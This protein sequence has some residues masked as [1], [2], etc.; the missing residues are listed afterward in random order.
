MNITASRNSTTKV[1]T[2]VVAVTEY[3]LMVT[4]VHILPFLSGADGN[5]DESGRMH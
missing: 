4:P 5:V 3:D 2:Y 1:T